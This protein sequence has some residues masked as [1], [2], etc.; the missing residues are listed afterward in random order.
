V[1]CIV[2][3]LVLDE[4]MSWPVTLGAGLVLAA[5]ALTVSDAST[6]ARDEGG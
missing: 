6:R 3:W 4:T 5:V 2:G 1:A